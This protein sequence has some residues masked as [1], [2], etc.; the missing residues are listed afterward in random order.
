MFPLTTQRLIL[1]P[2]QDSDLDAIWHATTIPHFTDGLE[3]VPPKSKRELLALIRKLG[4][5]DGFIPLVIALQEDPAQCIGQ[6]FLKRVRG[7]WYIGYWIL[8]QFQGNG[9]ATEAGEAMIEYAFNVLQAE[10]VYA[11]CMLWNTKSRAVLQRLGMTRRR[12]GYIHKNGKSI[13]AHVFRKRKDKES[14]HQNA[15]F[16]HQ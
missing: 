4:I 13:D 15:I 11:H 14:K 1:R 9:Y 2:V 3:W 10:N 7:R 6:F 16:L 12:K 5:Q 8:P